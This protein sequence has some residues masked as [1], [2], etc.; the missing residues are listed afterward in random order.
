[1]LTYHRA[2][3]EAGRH[4]DTCTPHVPSMYGSLSGDITDKT[5]LFSGGVLTERTSAA[6]SA[7]ALGRTFP[8]NR[9]RRA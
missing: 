3:G 6:S 2:D 7:S 4:L 9:L 8:L 1:M 5:S